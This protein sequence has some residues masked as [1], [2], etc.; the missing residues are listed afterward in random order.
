[1]GKIQFKELR[2]YR[3][4][5]DFIHSFDEPITYVAKGRISEVSSELEEP[6][7]EPGNSW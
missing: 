7:V 1:M 2:I 4:R 6:E 5:F 3:Q